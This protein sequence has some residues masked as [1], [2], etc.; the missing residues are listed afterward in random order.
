LWPPLSFEELIFR[1]ED[2]KVKAAARWNTY[3]RDR[4]TWIRFHPYA[5]E[6][7]VS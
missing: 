2:H 5:D 3:K 4:N 7:R 6:L 1:S